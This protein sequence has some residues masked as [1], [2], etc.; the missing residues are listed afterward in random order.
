[1]MSKNLITLTMVSITAFAI[2][3]FLLSSV[4]PSYSSITLDLENGHTDN[5]N[6]ASCHIDQWSDWEGSHHAKSMQVPNEE[7]ILGDFDDKEVIID[8]HVSHFYKNGDEFWVRTEDN[9]HKIEFAFGIDPLQ[10]YLI[11]MEDG[12]FQTLPLSW[13]SRPV[14]VGGQ[15]WFHI[16][17]EDYIQPND[18]LHWQQPLQNWNGMC[19][20]CHSSGLKR[21]FDPQNNSFNTSWDEINV[22]C[23]SCHGVNNDVMGT[24]SR[25]DAWVFTE[26]SYSATW[27]GL[28]PDQSEIE[29]CAGCHSRREP[30]TDGFG[31]TD[32]Y[33]DAFLPT[34][35]LTPEYFSDGQIKDEDYVW[36]SFLQSKMYAEGVI[37]SDCHD[38]HSLKIKVDGNNMC[39]TCHQASHFDN[40]THHKHADLSTGSECVSCHMPARTYM[41][42]DDRRDHSFRI[43]RPDLNHV[44][45]SPDACTNCHEDKEPEWAANQIEDWFGATRSPHYG[46]AMN[47]ASL[48]TPEG[49]WKLDEILKD[50]T[51]PEIIRGSGHELLSNYPNFNSYNT[52]STGLKSNE[53]LVRLGAVKASS[54]IPIKEREKI[55]LPLL[56]DE[57]RAIRTEVVRALSDMDQELVSQIFKDPYKKAKDEF[58]I[59]QK[60]ASW[61][62]EGPYNLGLFFGAQNEVIL[63][64]SLYLQS[65]KIDPYF[66]ASYINL[67]D[68]YRGIGNEKS[69][70]KTLDR[71][72][73]LMPENADLNFSKGLSLIRQSRGKEAL[74]HLEKAAKVA[75]ENTR[76]TYIYEVAKKQLDEDK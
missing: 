46:I 44:S 61:R 68:H 53:A 66:T 19:A 10:Q 71:G 50:E 20:D 6:C 26:N 9:E 30:L 72:L 51:V 13:D 40:I 65:I 57:F 64:E 49:E 25:S 38:P 56:N 34:S 67:A 3:F 52:I 15:R 55:L 22:G 11:A 29:V 62:G 33:L 41:G 1:M 73:A 74:Y 60:Q 16:Y 5:P 27:A 47:L 37:C 24:K 17:G 31:A 63:T 18:R 35:I 4:S 39:T 75:P 8:G 42:V 14:E 23:V 48:G 54:F 2:S 76:Y 28:K 21:D 58:L 7:N 45:N 59:A 69:T 43:P 36:G 32:R 12:K 70:L